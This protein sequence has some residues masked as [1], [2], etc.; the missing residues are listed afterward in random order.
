MVSY[1][2]DPKVEIL[3]ADGS[4]TVTVIFKGNLSYPA[5]ENVKEQLNGAC[6]TY[7]SVK[8]I[9]IDMGS[10]FHIDYAVVNSFRT[11]VEEMHAKGI[12]VDFVNF[13]DPAVEQSFNR[14][15][16]ESVKQT[17]PGKE[18]TGDKRS[19]DEEKTGYD[20][21]AY[22]MNVVS[23]EHAI[24]MEDKEEEKISHLRQRAPSSA[25]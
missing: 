22:H 10:V 21:G 18:E 17:V 5:V 1:E 8:T 16:V 6:D 20:N 15:K 25:C 24:N 9:S 14:G 2:V 4:E 23:N 19:G 11:I 3:S 13:I 7:A 12:F